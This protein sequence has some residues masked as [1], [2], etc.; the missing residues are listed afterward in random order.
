MII[1]KIVIREFLILAG[2][3][4]I[5]PALVLA[6]LAQQHSWD[7]LL[8]SAVREVFS[9]RVFSDQ[10][11]IGLWVRI[12][13]P[14]ILVQSIRAWYWSQRSTVGKRW[15]Y[16]YFSVLFAG[17]ACWSLSSAWDLFRFMSALGDMPAEIGQ[18]FELEGSNLVI[19]LG[20]AFLTFHCARIFLNPSQKDDSSA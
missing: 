6:L 3:F 11:R 12:L 19:G 1:W 15:A 17:V 4:S 14:Y 10:P 8:S 5:L 13:A 16:L 2:S 20:A 7:M 9:G 18:F